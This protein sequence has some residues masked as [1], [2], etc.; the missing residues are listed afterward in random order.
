[1]SLPTAL[2]AVADGDGRAFGCLWSTAGK[3][4]SKARP[5]TAWAVWEQSSCEGSGPLCLSAVCAGLAGV[6]L[7]HPLICKLYKAFWEL[8]TNLSLP[9]LQNVIYQGAGDK[10]TSEYRSVVYYQQRHQRWMETVKVCAG[11]C[12]SRARTWQPAAPHGTGGEGQPGCPAPFLLHSRGFF[13][14]RL[15]FPLR[16]STRPICGSPSGTAPPATVST[17]LCTALLVVPLGCGRGAL[18]VSGV[19]R[20]EPHEQPL[21]CSAVGT[22]R[23]CCETWR[24]RVAVPGLL[25]PSCQAEI[26]SSGCL[27]LHSSSWAMCWHCLRLVAMGCGKQR[28]CCQLLRRA[29]NQRPRDGVALCT[30]LCANAGVG[31][32]HSCSA[33]HDGGLACPSCREGTWGGGGWVG[34]TLPAPHP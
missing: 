20:Q 10:P 3:G 1:M 8:T 21:S 32:T 27:P 9:S 30:F 14:L 34:L 26:Q 33:G 19:Q 13:S 24:K 2:V 16:M 4:C 29:E 6:C 22:H 28:G 23:G 17:A 31:A 7:C 5:H 18:A 11:L 12:Q 25:C 15:L